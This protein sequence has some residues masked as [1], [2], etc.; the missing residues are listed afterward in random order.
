LAEE[1]IVASGNRV[2]KDRLTPLFGGS[3]ADEFKL[4]LMLFCHSENPRA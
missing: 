4:K 3:A 2:S 1:D